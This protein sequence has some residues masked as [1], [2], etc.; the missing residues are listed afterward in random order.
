MEG[1][2]RCIIWCQLEMFIE[3]SNKVTFD[4]AVITSEVFKKKNG[5]NNFYWNT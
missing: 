1:V 2:C 4:V 5:P 3:M